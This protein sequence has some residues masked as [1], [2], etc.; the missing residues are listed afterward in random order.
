MKLLNKWCEL[1]ILRLL[2]IT[3][4]ASRIT[5]NISAGSTSVILGKRNCAQ[6]CLTNCQV[7]SNGLQIITLSYI[8]RLSV[9]NYPLNVGELQHFGDVNETYGHQVHCLHLLTLVEPKLPE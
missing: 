3:N 8:I 5:S 4:I 7:C 6:V 2:S 1:I 9:H